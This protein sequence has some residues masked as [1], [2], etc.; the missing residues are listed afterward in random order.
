MFYYNWRDDCL[1]LVYTYIRLA[2]S[3]LLPE[4]TLDDELHVGRAF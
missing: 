1:Q 2:L 4:S 3:K